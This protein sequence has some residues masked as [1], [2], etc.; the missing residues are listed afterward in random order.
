MQSTSL[1]P[2]TIHNSPHIPAHLEGL[3]ILIVDDQV[4]H[5]A[6]MHEILLGAG[7]KEVYTAGNGKDAFEILDL[8]PEIGLVLLDLVMPG[9]DGYEVCRR[10]KTNAGTQDIS[11]IVVT[12]GAIQIESALS[13]SFEAGAIDFISKPLNKFDLLARCQS[14]LSLYSEKQQNLYQE[15]EL[16]QREEKYRSLFQNC[17]DAMLILTPLDLVIRDINPSGERLF[18]ESREDLQGRALTS[19]CPRGRIPEEYKQVGHLAEGQSVSL[20]TQKQKENGELISVEIAFTGFSLQGDSRIMA[21][22]SDISSR[23]LAIADLK[24]S[25]ERLALAAIDTTS[26]IWDWDIITGDIYFSDNWRKFFG[27]PKKNVSKGMEVWKNHLHPE[28]I[29]R[30]VASMRT[31]W[32]QDSATFMEEHRLKNLSGSYRWVLS[33]GRALRNEAGEV[34]RMVGSLIDITDKKLSEIRNNQSRKWESMDRFAGGLVHGL[35]HMVGIITS[36]CDAIAGKVPHQS[37][38]FQQIARIRQ[39]TDWTRSMANQLQAVS[40]KSQ[41][42][43]EYVFLNLEVGNL[44]Q[45]VQPLLIDEID[46]ETDFEENLPPVFGDHTL[47]CQVLRALIANAGDSMPQGGTCALSTSTHFQDESLHLDGREVSSGNYVKL[48]VSDTGCGM[49]ESVLAQAFEPFFTTKTEGNSSYSAG[50]GL[51][52]VY[53]IM[54]LHGGWVSVVSKPSLGTRFDLFFPILNESDTGRS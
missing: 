27:I 38:V 30:V 35:D 28:E 52:A 12:G 5:L 11:V 48:S 45:V 40:S 23:M 51:S 4:D 14:A 22:V 46:V 21:V 18:G 32:N 25:E 53:A 42:Q 2:E 39:A 19:W 34:V 36:C 54:K 8:H 43:L 15:L 44:L 1:N 49:E 6:L 10:I 3:G 37:E 31:H 47:I 16:L 50:L 29:D 24:K 9:L 26:G 17:F 7:Y 13:K 20:E 33:R 41:I